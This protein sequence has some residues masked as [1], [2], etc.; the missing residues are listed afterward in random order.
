MLESEIKTYPFYAKN[1]E[2]DL[3]IKFEAWGAGQVIKPGTESNDVGFES[4]DWHMAY[5]TII[6]NYKGEKAMPDKHFILADDD[7][8]P[9]C[10]DDGKDQFATEKEA[11]T[12]AKEIATTLEVGDSIYIYKSVKK[13]TRGKIPVRVKAIK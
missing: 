4:D 12:A 8:N 10:T 9:V 5:F 11:E 13:V 6:K 3:I 7:F 1:P 2:T